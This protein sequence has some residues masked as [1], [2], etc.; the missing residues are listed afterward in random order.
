VNGEALYFERRGRGEALMLLHGFTGSGRSLDPVARSMA[1]EF[2]TLAPD[3]PGHGR[4]IGGVVPRDYGFERCLERLVT[5][6]ACAG[7]SRAHWLGYSM[8]ARLALGCAIRHP[9]RVASLVLIG[10][11][12]GIADDGERAARR[13]TDEALARRIETEGVEAF[14]DAWVS[15]PIFATQRRFGS[16]FLEA[17]RRERLANVAS[18]LAA[19]LRG[20]GPGS[21]PPLFDALE[22]V[23][24]PVLLVA[25]ALDRPF[26]EQA[27][28]LARR[29]PAAEVCEIE[30]AGHAVHLEQPVAFI[31][32][33]LDF[34]RR[35]ARRAPSTIAIPVQETAS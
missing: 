16:A 18:E 11:R 8:G 5:T 2:T 20:L 34:L 24:V 19:G 1:H 14:V 21:Q 13:D 28:E 3:L 23:E 12:A 29:L 22:R 10:A 15:Q 25:G 4:S 9:E 30:D 27:R 6:L 31:A 33:A 7:H 26:V 32:A 17:G 35:A